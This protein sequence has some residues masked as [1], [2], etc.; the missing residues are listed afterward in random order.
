MPL[1]APQQSASPFNLNLLLNFLLTLPQEVICVFHLISALAIL[2]SHSPE[3]PNIL[4]KIF[5]Y[6]FTSLRSA[7]TIGHLSPSENLLLSLTRREPSPVLV[8]LATRLSV[9]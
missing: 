5:F 3:N 8:G 6:H 4:L 7:F 2:A 1:S 9:V